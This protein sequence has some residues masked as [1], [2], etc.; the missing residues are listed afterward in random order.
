MKRTF[1][2]QK[3]IDRLTNEGRINE[4]TTEDYKLMDLLDGKEGTDYNWESFVN[5][6]P[7]V[8]IFAKEIEGGGAY[9]GLQDCV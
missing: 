9:V 3:M 6:R 1:K 5:D 8:W 2:K 4:L 7:L